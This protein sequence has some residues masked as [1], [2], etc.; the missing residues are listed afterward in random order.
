MFSCPFVETERQHLC[1]PCD[2]AFTPD[3]NDAENIRLDTSYSKSSARV[4]GD[5]NTDWMAQP[6]VYLHGL[7]YGFQP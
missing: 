6:A 3:V 7:S 2:A 4:D 5:R 1:E